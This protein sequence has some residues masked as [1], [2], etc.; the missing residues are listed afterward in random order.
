MAMTIHTDLSVQGLLRKPAL[1]AFHAYGIGSGSTANNSFV[2]FPTVTFNEGGHYSPISGA[3]TAPIDGLYEFAWS[4][5]G[6]TADTVYRSR[7]YVNLVEILHSELRLDTIA[8]G[9]NYGPS[10]SRVH[11]VELTSGDT[12][13][14]WHR[15]DSGVPA[16]PGV[17][18]PTDPFWNFSGKYIG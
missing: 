8:S 4:Y 1:P 10:A 7:L 12:V 6:N 3:F 16:Y 13:R 14:V 11:Q 5:I 2:V 9:A 18:A 17:D 15:S